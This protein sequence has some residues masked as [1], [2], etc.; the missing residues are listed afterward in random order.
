MYILISDRF[1]NHF[2]DF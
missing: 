2:F 1:I